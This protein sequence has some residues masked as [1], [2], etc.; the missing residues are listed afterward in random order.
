[1]ST[2]Q[3]AKKQSA[4]AE[5]PKR[6]HW[7]HGMYE[8]FHEQ[9]LRVEALQAEKASLEGHIRS[10]IIER[11]GQR[12]ISQDNY[13]EMRHYQDRVDELER[14]LAKAVPASKTIKGGKVTQLR[15][16]K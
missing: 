13:R 10:L 9:L 5:Q 11:D 6:K 15:P 4:A 14:D 16:A 1:M 8:A 7:I 3:A 2:A 12:R